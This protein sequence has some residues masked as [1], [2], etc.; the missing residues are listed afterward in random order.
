MLLINPRMLLPASA[1]RVPCLCP[2][3][4]HSPLSTQLLPSQPPACNVAKAS[5][6]CGALLEFH[7]VSIGLFLQPISV[8]NGSP[9]LK[10]FPPL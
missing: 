4:T 9:A 6:C 5:S 2:A 10:L 1:A 8:L 7:K 3:K